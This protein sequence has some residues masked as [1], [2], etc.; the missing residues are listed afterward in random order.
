MKYASP[1]PDKSYCKLSKN[2][3]TLAPLTSSDKLTFTAGEQSI[4][5]VFSFR[6]SSNFNIPYTEIDW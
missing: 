1:N 6:D 2:K 5:A 3:N 4:Y